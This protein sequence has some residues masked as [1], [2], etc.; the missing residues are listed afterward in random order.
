[1]M[2]IAVLAILGL[3]AGAIYWFLRPTGLD[4]LPDQAVIAPGGS[5]ATIE[6]DNTVTVGLEISNVSD[7]DLTVVKAEIT[8]SGRRHAAPGDDRAARAG[9]RGFHT[10]R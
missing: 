7:V 5:L 8:A 9:E 6:E 2:S 4:T 3:V 10:R 1:M